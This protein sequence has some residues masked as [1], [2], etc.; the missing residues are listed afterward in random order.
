MKNKDIKIPIIVALV[1]AIVSLG[2][3]F[4]AFNSSLFING[5][6]II[7][8][9]KWEIVFEGL[10]SEHPDVL[11]SPTIPVGTGGT[12]VTAPTIKNNSTEISNFVVTLTS[13]GDSITYNFKIH[14]RGDYAASVT[15]VVKNSGIYLTSDTSKR[16]SELNTLNNIEYKL[17][18]TESNL[19][20]G[21]DIEKDCLAPGEEEL[22][23]LRIVF[24]SSNETDTSVLPSADL[25]LD[26]LG[27]VVN[28]TQEDSCSQGTAGG[29]SASANILMSVGTPSANGS[30]SAASV[31][32]PTVSGTSIS[33][34]TV[35]IPSEGDSVTYPISFSSST[36]R[37]LTSVTIP[38]VADLAAANP[39]LDSSVFE[40]IEVI[41]TDENGI[42]ISS[43]N[44]PCSSN[45]LLTQMNI[46]IRHKAGT[47]SITGNIVL[48]T[49]DLVLNEV[50]NCSEPAIEEYYVSST[51]QNGGYTYN[52][53][54][55]KNSI[56]SL[57]GEPYIKKINDN[58]SICTNINSTEYCFDNNTT[59]ASL[60]STC[61]VIGGY[62]VDGVGSWLGLGYEVGTTCSNIQIIPDGEG[63]VA[64]YHDLI[65]QTYDIEY[66]DIA[67]FAYP[68]NKYIYI[69]RFYNCDAQ[70]ESCDYSYCSI[71]YPVSN[72][73]NSFRCGNSSDL[74]N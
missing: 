47:S 62:D 72:S 68:G 26:Q 6:G 71:K 61:S 55:N 9:S 37:E 10:D 11:G 63:G 44:R 74:N 43:T 60:S 31:T 3:A 4:A 2:V 17:Y 22:V 50:N 19:D 53:S 46:V 49:M 48:P 41:V 20:V 38:S 7:E 40:N 21:N 42:A 23:S 35:S 29:G 70:T 52:W 57:Y 32:T 73:Y 24:S 5:N 18:Y 51:S 58:Y 30:Q 64:N 25:V 8:S 69:S 39:S 66:T 1:I 28:Y 45:N 12:V 13:P 27:I 56:P 34:A 54:Q 33:G 59:G 15:S 16:T 36:A 65:Y 67:D 14:N